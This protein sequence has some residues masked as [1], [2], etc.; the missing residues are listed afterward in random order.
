MENRTNDELPPAVRNLAIDFLKLLTLLSGGGVLLMSTA[1]LT[2]LSGEPK[3]GFILWLM[4]GGVYL[5]STTLWMLVSSIRHRIKVES[6]GIIAHTPKQQTRLIKDCNF[7]YLIFGFS[8]LV[9]SVP[10]FMY[11]YSFAT[12]TKSPSCKEVLRKPSKQK[13]SRLPKQQDPIKP[14]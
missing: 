8:I 13:M 4:V 3:N 14:L 5:F 10:V 1:L 6:T 2:Y 9:M 11:S 7:V 12:D